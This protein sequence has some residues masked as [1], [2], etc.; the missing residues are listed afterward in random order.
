MCNEN[1]WL[2]IKEANHQ[3]SSIICLRASA[4][5]GALLGHAA[6]A[7]IGSVAGPL[8]TLG[9]MIVGAAVGWAI[10][11]GV[12]YIRNRRYH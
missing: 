8:G 5:G 3:A 7:A 6:G 10:G 12:G 1:G 2:L 9:G 11:Y 4:S